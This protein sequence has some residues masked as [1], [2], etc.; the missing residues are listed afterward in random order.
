MLS[1]PSST[2]TLP[3]S[4]SLW[5]LLCTSSGERDQATAYWDLQGERREMGSFF[6]E[7]RGIENSWVDT[8]HP[9]IKPSSWLFEWLCVCVHANGCSQIALTLFSPLFASC[10]KQVSSRWSVKMP[11]CFSIASA[12]C[13]WTG[14][15]TRHPPER[16]ERIRGYKV[17]FPWRQE[18]E[19]DEYP[20]LPLLKCQTCPSSLTSK[21]FRSCTLTSLGT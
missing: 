4:K 18:C 14:V 10:L 19:D 12:L 8:R 11:L 7:M 2:I 21:L 20:P 13:I 3:P 6:S 15:Y 16:A 9:V 17:R 1:A 5:K